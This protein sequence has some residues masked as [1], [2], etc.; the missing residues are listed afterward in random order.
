MIVQ[1]RPWHLV[2]SLFGLYPLFD[3]VEGGGSSAYDRRLFKR[4]GTCSVL[5]ACFV[6]ETE[7][8]TG[9]ELNKGYVDRRKSV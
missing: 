7:D 9:G 1:I 5:D 2:R 6:V 4:G 8:F 3:G